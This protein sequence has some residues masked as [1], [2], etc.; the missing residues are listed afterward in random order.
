VDRKSGGTWCIL[1]YPTRKPAM[2]THSF[3]NQLFRSLFPMLVPRCLLGGEKHK[4][5]K[6]WLRRGITLLVAT[7]GHLL[8]HLTKMASLPLSLR[9]TAA[10]SDLSS[11]RLIA[12]WM[13]AALGG[14]WSRL[15]SGFAGNAA[16][17]RGWVGAT[18]AFQSVLV[19]ATVRSKLE[20]MARRVPSRDGNGGGWV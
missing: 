20:G 3:A 14:R 12:S 11:M 18:G 10:S 5:E 9:Q 13:G 17:W 15:S 6:A 16:A 1:L 2:Q 19:S 4:S 8:N 7:P